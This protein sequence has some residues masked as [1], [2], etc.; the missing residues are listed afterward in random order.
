MDLLDLVYRIKECKMKKSKMK[1]F[2]IFDIAYNTEKFCFQAKNE[3]AAKFC[4]NFW[5]RRQALL[6]IK[7]LYMLNE[8]DRPFFEGNIHNEYV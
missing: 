2:Q 3:E 8:V 4:F 7:H 1:L 6:P 5:L